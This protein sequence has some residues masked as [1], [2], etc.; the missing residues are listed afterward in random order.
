MSV[1]QCTGLAL[2]AFNEII[3]FRFGQ[4]YHRIVTV[5]AIHCTLIYAFNEII[6][7]LL[8]KPCK[9]LNYI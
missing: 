1:A 6:K 2:T 4:T 8:N 9:I 7:F 5:N 3:M